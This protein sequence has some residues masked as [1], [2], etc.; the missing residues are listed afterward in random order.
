MSI[1]S[2]FLMGMD[3]VISKP[4]DDRSDGVVLNLGGGTNIK[5][6]PGLSFGLPQYD[7]NKDTLVSAANS[8]VQIH[9]YHFFEHLTDPLWC[10][11]ECERVLVKGGHINIVVP[12]YNSS[13]Q[14]QDLTHKSSF[15]ENTWA[16]T[17]NNPYYGEYKWQLAVHFNII[18]GVVE[19]NL[20][21]MTQLI[22]I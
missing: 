11:C 8:V 6:I 13:M 18:I 15:N 19:R 2:L 4:L 21:L 22:K 7:A 5:D 3:R 17:F 10:L 14:A 20:C 12:Y 9:A 1:E 16:T